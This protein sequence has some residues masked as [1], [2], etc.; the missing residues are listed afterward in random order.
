MPFACG[1]KLM[2]QIWMLHRNHILL[3]VIKCYFFSLCILRWQVRNI[4]CG[5]YISSVVVSMHNTGLPPHSDAVLNPDQDE[6]DAYQLR[7]SSSLPKS[8]SLKQMRQYEGKT[9]IVP[10]WMQWPRVPERVNN[11][12]ANWKKVKVTTVTTKWTTLS[13]FPK[14]P[15]CWCWRQKIGADIVGMVTLL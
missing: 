8:S 11:L 3:T 9:T 15:F 5:V 1:Y 6:Y 12:P 2:L 13:M 4:W 7:Y 14:L 10:R